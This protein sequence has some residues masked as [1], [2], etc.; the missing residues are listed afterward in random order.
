MEQ[1]IDLLLMLVVLMGLVSLASGRVGVSIRTV[2]VQGVL[3]GLLALVINWDDLS[4]HLA[5]WAA[6][7]IALKGFCLPWLLNRSV[8]HAGVQSEE[9]PY[10]GFTTSLVLGAVALAIAFGLANIL[11]IPG[12]AGSRLI[13][14]ASLTTVFIGLLLLVTRRLAASQVL[15]YIVLENGIFVFGLAVAAELPVI[16]EMGILLDLFVGVFIMGIAILRIKG[17]FG[18]MDSSLLRGLKD[19]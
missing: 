4:L 2:A 5:L 11:H 15:G 8:R 12:D 17:E 3:L 7:S 16:V 9:H 10:V 13:A 19:Q 1:L 14:P 6:L 18:H